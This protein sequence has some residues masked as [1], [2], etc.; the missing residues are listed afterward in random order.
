MVEYESLTT[1]H[2]PDKIGNIK[3]ILL[4]YKQIVKLIS[5]NNSI[6]LLKV[7]PFRY[8]KDTFYINIAF[9]RASKRGKKIEYSLLLGMGATIKYHFDCDAKGFIFDRIE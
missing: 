9:Y 7:A 4:E 8:S 2:L 3:I 5:R 1:S 6:E